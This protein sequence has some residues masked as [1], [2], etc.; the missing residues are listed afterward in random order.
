[1][2][3]LCVVFSIK[4]FSPVIFNGKAEMTQQIKMSSSVKC[5]FTVCNFNFVK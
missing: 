5:Q 4:F 1:M 3:K 2:A